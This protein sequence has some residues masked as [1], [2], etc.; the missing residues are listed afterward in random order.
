MLQIAPRYR[1][2]PSR[3]P[4]VPYPAKRRGLS[5]PDRGL[6]RAALRTGP[7]LLPTDVPDL[8][9]LLEEVEA[10]AAGESGA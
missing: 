4:P 2:P 7:P 6:I 1:I 10:T 5:Q 8:G 9:P 3:L